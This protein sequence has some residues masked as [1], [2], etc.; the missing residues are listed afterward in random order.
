MIWIVVQLAI[1]EELRF[2]HP[3]MFLIGLGIA[4][5]SIPWGSQTFQAWRRGS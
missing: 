3:T 5:A 1:I 4:A 2:L